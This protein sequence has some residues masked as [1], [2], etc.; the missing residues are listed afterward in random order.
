MS[1]QACLFIDSHSFLS[2]VRESPLSGLVG[3]PSLLSRLDFATHW[4]TRNFHKPTC[5]LDLRRKGG[6]SGPGF[7]DG[8][9]SP[10]RAKADYAAWRTGTRVARLSWV[11]MTW[12]FQTS[13]ATGPGSQTVAYGRHILANPTF[14]L[15]RLMG[16]RVV[17]SFDLKSA[18][19]R[20]PLL[21]LFRITTHLFDRSFASSAV[22]SSLAPKC[23]EMKRVGW[24]HYAP[25]TLLIVGQ[26]MVIRKRG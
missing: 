24:E 25:Y 19:D 6:D 18:T 23:L 11:F 13:K 3:I 20:W 22:N 1:V 2:F 12:G 4:S 9:L 26:S 5:F 7:L 8:T 17:F 15:D 14:R 16:S 10:D 21:I